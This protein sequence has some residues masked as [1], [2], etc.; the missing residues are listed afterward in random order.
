M[1]TF[2]SLIIGMAVFIAGL[3]GTILIFAMTLGST[4]MIFLMRRDPELISETYLTLFY[5]CIILIIICVV[6]F[7]AIIPLNN[8]FHFLPKIKRNKAVPIHN[9]QESVYE[10]KIETG[11]SKLKFGFFPRIRGK[12]EKSII[13]KQVSDE[14]TKIDI[15]RKLISDIKDT[16]IPP[17]KSELLRAAIMALDHGETELAREFMKYVKKIH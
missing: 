8:K 13:E 12:K 3:L 14:D 9:K 7:W 6:Y 15:E 4:F 10:A 2:D 17:N 1:K 16:T 11:K 5:L